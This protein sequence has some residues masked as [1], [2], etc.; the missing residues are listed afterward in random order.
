M[1]TIL[2]A[3]VRQKRNAGIDEQDKREQRQGRC[4]DYT[5]FFEVRTYQVFALRGGNQYRDR[6]R[7]DNG[8][9]IVTEVVHETLL[10]HY[11]DDIELC[12]ESH[13]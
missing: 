13:L 3:G 11:L 4:A 9:L 10:P 5:R 2:R 12:Q 7:H 1:R 6:K 8:H